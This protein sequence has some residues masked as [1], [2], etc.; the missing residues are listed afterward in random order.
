[1]DDGQHPARSLGA[2]GLLGLSQGKK[3]GLAENLPIVIVTKNLRAISP[4]V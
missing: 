2:T 1:M 4:R 3:A